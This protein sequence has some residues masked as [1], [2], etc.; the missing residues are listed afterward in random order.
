[1]LIE[2][3]INAR[4]IVFK[5]GTPIDK[6]SADAEAAPPSLKILKSVYGIKKKA[7]NP[8][9]IISAADSIAILRA[10]INLSLFLAP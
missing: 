6:T 1:M 8:S 9:V 3:G 5:A 2:A 10:D 4:H 7:K